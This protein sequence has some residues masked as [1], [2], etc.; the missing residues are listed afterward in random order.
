MDYKREFQFFEN[1]PDVIYLDN[2]GTTLKPI[3]VINKINDFYLNFST[4]SHNQDSDLSYKTF[5]TIENIRKQIA[6]FINCSNKDEIIFNSGATFGLNQICFGM[7]ELTSGDEIIINKYEHASNI[8]PWIKI[9]KIKNLKI[10][11]INFLPNFKVDIE[12]LKKLITSKTKIISYASISNTTAMLQDIEKINKT[13]K[14]INPD[15][16]IIIDAAQS[17]AHIK[18]DVQKWGADFIVGSA[19]KMYGPTGIGFMW[20]KIEELKKIEPLLY[21]G[22]MITRVNSQN[23]NYDLSKIPHRFEGGTINGAGI[24]GFSEAVKYLTKISL[25]KIRQH[26]RMLIDYFVDQ[27]KKNHLSKKIEIYAANSNIC[28]FNVKNVFSQDVVT[29]MGSVNNIILRSGDNCAKLLLDTIKQK[30]IIRLSVA[31]YNTKDDIDKLIAAIINE[32]VFL[33][34]L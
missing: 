16:K 15:I 11:F 30:S 1:N 13:I 4:N 29:H 31:I 25:E 27:V 9:A 32:D 34:R 8:I 33:G 23:L 26:E 10:K 14:K 18:T 24:F 3:S 22:S 5:Q 20:G 28:I 2:A 19:H 6:D 17:L 21:G 12:S 7:T